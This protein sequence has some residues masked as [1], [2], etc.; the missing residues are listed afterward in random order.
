MEKTKIIAELVKEGLSVKEAVAV[1]REL[2]IEVKAEKVQDNKVLITPIAQEEK[3]KI[4]TKHDK[5]GQLKCKKVATFATKEVAKD[6]AELFKDIK[7]K[8]NQLSFARANK[9]TMQKKRARELASIINRYDCE[10]VITEKSIALLDNN[11]C[12]VGRFENRNI[13]KKYATLDSEYIVSM[14]R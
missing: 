10:L 6:Y 13:D 1:Y 3:K 14:A 4:D 2:G 9:N 12:E 8:C 5:N 7:S 11:K